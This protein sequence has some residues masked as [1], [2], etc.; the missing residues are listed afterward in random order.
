MIVR[1]QKIPE[2]GGDKLAQVLVSIRDG[3]YVFDLIN[4]G[5]V[6]FFFYFPKLM[7]F[8]TLSLV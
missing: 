6:F 8:F 7:G 4:F 5:S 1:S 2:G 3:E